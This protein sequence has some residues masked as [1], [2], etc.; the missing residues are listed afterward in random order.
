MLVFVIVF[1][2]QVSRKEAVKGTGGI[3]VRCHAPR[4]RHCN[5]GAH[6]VSH[7]YL[8][9]GRVFRFGHSAHL[10]GL[11]FSLHIHSKGAIRH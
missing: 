2:P 1:T 5:R 10:S 9:D 8:I 3:A 7:C 6:N 4:T 11:I